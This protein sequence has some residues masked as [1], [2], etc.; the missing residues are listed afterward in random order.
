MSCWTHHDFQEGTTL[1]L[2]VPDTWGR[3]RMNTALTIADQVVKGK[4]MESVALSV[5]R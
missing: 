1:E 5:K 3:G 4:E 2:E